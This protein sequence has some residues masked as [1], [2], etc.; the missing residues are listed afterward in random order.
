MSLWVAV[1]EGRSEVYL[2]RESAVRRASRE[3]DSALVSILHDAGEHAETEI[4]RYQKLL[5]E[6]REREQLAL[7]EL[8]T[9]I[10][11]ASAVPENCDCPRCSG[12][13]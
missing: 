13:F 8:D 9:L 5:I 7:R 10:A 12:Y 6:A 1:V 4:V 11:L 3:P 2:D